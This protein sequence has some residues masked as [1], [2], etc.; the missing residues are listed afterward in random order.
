[1]RIKRTVA[2][3]LAMILG[4]T[5]GMTAFA[6]TLS[7]AP[8][9]TPAAGPSAM[10]GAPDQETQAEDARYDESAYRNIGWDMTPEAVAAA[11]QVKARS[12]TVTV[13]EGLLLYELEMKKLVYRFEDGIMVSRT[14]TA[15]LNNAEA[16]SYLFFSLFRRYGIP[17]LA[18]KRKA[19]WGD[20]QAT[21]T[22]QRSIEGL[23][24]R[25]EA[26]R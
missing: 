12:T 23:T 1:M 20:V 21:V 22:L 15:K 5:S 8:E 26:L 11:K 25:Y 2:C 4:L 17:I 18:E 3:L 13:Q 10:A 9:A 24:I 6:E 19:V 14:F 16:F 7:A